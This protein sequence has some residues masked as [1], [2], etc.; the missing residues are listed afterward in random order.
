MK[1]HWWKALGVLLVF[2]TIIQGFLG[3]VPKMDILNESIRSLYFHVP[4]WFAMIILMGT[5]L[6]YSIKHLRDQT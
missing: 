6:V 2:Y 1:K 4:M 3:G 5:S